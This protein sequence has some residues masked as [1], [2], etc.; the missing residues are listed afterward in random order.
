MAY[1]R[2]LYGGTTYAPA[3][4][5][6]EW[7]AIDLARRHARPPRRRR[8]RRVRIAPRPGELWRTAAYVHPRAHRRGIGTELAR[9]LEAIAGSRGARRLQSGVAEPDEAGLRLF[10][11]LGYRKVRVFREM[12]IELAGR[13]EAPRWPGG[14]ADWCDFHIATDRFDASLWVV[15]R[16]EDEIVAGAIR[17]STVRS[18]RRRSAASG[19]AASAVSG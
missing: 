14:L 3:D 11:D 12:R 5:E 18:S 8:G 6:A 13:P 1:E 9:R 17:A 10:C 16:D 19:N 4:L 7:E 2:S 15:V